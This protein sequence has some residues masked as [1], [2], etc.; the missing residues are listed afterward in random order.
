MERRLSAIF[1]ADMVGYSRLMEADESGTH[2][3]LALLRKE[4][5]YPMITKNRGRIVKL[6]GDGILVEF[7]CAIDAVRCAI[8]LQESIAIREQAEL[9]DRRV[10]FRI[11][12]NLDNVI[13][14]GDDIYGD[15]INIA[16]RL[17]GM[18]E[19]GGVLISHSIRDDVA[20]QIDTVFFDNGERKFKN[21]SRAIRVWSWPRKLPSLRALGKPLVFVAGFEGRG[22]EEEARLAVDLRDEL[23]AHLAR[24][25]GLVITADQT[26]AHYV[27]KGG[28]RFAAGRTRIFARLIAVDGNRQIWS[29]RYEENTGDIFEVLDRS[30]AHVA[31]SVRR[32][33]AAD[34]AAQLNTRPLDELSLEELLSVAGVSFFT[35]NKAGWRGG[36]EIA[37]QA[38][39]LAPDNFMALAM[40]AA[41]L[42]LAENL[43]GY[44]KTDDAIT[45][46]A[47]NR[48][49]KALRATNRSD[50][51]HVTHAG[52]LLYGRKRHRDAAAA[53]R[54]SLELNPEYN[55]GLW[56]LGAAQV[57][58]GQ[59][60]AGAQSA[61]RAVN[62]DIQDPYV[63]LYCRIAAY[64]HLGAERYDEA[65]DWFQ[66]ADQLAPGIMPNLVGLAVSY[67]LDGD[68]DSTHYAVTRLMEQEPEFSLCHMQPLPYRDE[69][70]WPRFVETLCSAGVPQ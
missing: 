6:M 24:L 43:Y 16:A 21:I 23:R 8:A 1:A 37:E 20:D 22:S 57:F 60:D 31:T 3:K 7:A 38:L 9:E 14:E 40:A 30:A 63:H 45:A 32:R 59:F 4:L 70:V 52:L 61:E 58:S 41:G 27:V 47:F 26:S 34:D 35:A 39:E 28:V 42:G 29:N 11:G 10:I 53:A 55:M 69:W 36:G 51:L 50:M 44:L 2:I 48:V 18:A 54:L 56:M 66:R 33:V 5:I 64:A 17:E 15:G 67:W 68:K 62:I 46:L 13:I 49:N 65:I 19:P 12:L 25:T